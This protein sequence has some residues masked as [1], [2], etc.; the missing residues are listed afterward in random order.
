[1]SFCNAPPGMGISGDAIVVI[2]EEA[3]VVVLRINF[4]DVQVIR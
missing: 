3:S 4:D 1:M 2:K